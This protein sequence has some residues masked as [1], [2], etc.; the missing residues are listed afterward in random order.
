MGG[1]AP[2]VSG[3]FRQRSE[4]AG[5]PKFFA[6]LCR[7]SSACLLPQPVGHLVALDTC[8]LMA[9]AFFRFLDFRVTAAVYESFCLRPVFVDFMCISRQCCV[10]F[11]ANH[12]C[13][14]LSV[15]FMFFQKVSGHRK[16]ACSTRLELIAHSDCL[17]GPICR[18]RRYSAGKGFSFS[19]G[20][21]CC[22]CGC[23]RRRR[24]GI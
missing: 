16:V 3:F 6:W 21:R 2:G 13:M 14:Q 23:K 8:R 10:R 12:R 4:V 24:F 15:N 9:R 1:F 20:T 7:F 19:H 17:R 22:S 18:A 5:W 11:W